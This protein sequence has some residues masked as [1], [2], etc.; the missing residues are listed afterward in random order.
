MSGDLDRYRRFV[1]DGSPVA[2]GFV[3]IAD[4]WACTNPSAG[5]GL[6]VGFL[7]A[8]QL[9]DV[10]RE[11]GDNPRALA[12]EFDRRTE[13]EVTPWYDAQIALD[14]TR[15]AEMDALR[16]GRHPPPPV[17][18]LA[19]A[20]LSLLSTIMADPD[21]FRVAMEYIGTVTPVQKLLRRP[22]VVE[23]IRAVRQALQDRPPMPMP[24][25]NRDQLLELVK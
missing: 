2:T 13:A 21:L 16:A 20:I 18:E 3:A 14:R 12:E 10:V 5:R 22:D 17:D 23:R 6:T 11:A 7:H 15:V 8:R 9:R 1:V 24:G 4:A 19:R 25:P